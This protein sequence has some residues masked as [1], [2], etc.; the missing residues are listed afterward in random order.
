MLNL[1]SVHWL[2]SIL[3]LGRTPHRPLCAALLKRHGQ[4]F[5]R[6]SCIAHFGDSSSGPRIFMRGLRLVL[7][8]PFHD[9]LIAAHH[10]WYMWWCGFLN[11]RNYLLRLHNETAPCPYPVLVTLL[12]H[13]PS[14]LEC[15]Y[16]IGDLVLVPTRLRLILHVLLDFQV[17]LTP[18]RVYSRFLTADKSLH[19][20]H[21][22]SWHIMRS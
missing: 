16:L 9:W 14:P 13:L 8:V 18:H 12:G 19:S 5:L 17:K 3:P 11:I 10:N 21:S 1:I 6:T 7:E 15:D 2:Q 20:F 4:Y 22:L